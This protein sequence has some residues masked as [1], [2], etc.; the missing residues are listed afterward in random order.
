MLTALLGT[1]GWVILAGGIIM[2]MWMM[3]YGMD[4]R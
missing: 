4:D 2:I 3:T 1:Y